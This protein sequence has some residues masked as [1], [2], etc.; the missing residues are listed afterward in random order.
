M[1]GMVPISLPVLKHPINKTSQIICKTLDTH[2]PLSLPVQITDPEL[3][4]LGPLTPA[5]L[6]DVVRH[7]SSRGS[8]APWND[9]TLAREAGFLSCA[10]PP[11]ACNDAASR[12]P[13][14]KPGGFVVQLACRIIAL[15][16]ST[17]TLT[18]SLILI[19]FHFFIMR[20]F[21]ILA[22][23]ALAVNGKSISRFGRCGAD[24]G[25]LTCA[26]SAFG[27]CCSKYNYCGSSSA[28]CD[29]GCQSGYG[30]CASSSTSSSPSAG[31][32]K[33]SSEG[34]CGGKG[35]KTC[36][37]SSFGN[38]CSKHG[39]CGS[40]PTYCGTGCNAAFG[41]CS[42]S[43][44]APVNVPTTLATVTRS[45]AAAPSSDVR[46][47]PNARCGWSR[48]AIGG[49]NCIGSRWGNCCSTWGFCGSTPD[50]C[51]PTKCQDKYGKCEST[52][53]FLS[54]SSATKS[55][56]SVAVSSTLSSASFTETTS[57]S[58]STR[59]ASSTLANSS[60]SS[61]TSSVTSSATSSSKTSSV[62]SSRSTTVS[63]SSSKTSSASS[64]SSA[65]SYSSS[66]SF[67]TTKTSSASS[68]SQA[69]SASSI[70]KASSS[71]STANTS[72][73]ISTRIS[74]S[75]SASSTPVS[76][77][78]SV[79]ST[80]TSSSSSF[81]STMTSSSSIASSTKTSSSSSFSASST[82]SSS[83]STVSSTAA[84]SSSSATSRRISS[85]SS[86]ISS[87]QSSS[88]SSSSSTTVLSSTSTSSSVSST[89]ASSSSSSVASSTLNPSSSSSMMTSTPAV[90]TPTPTPTP[91]A[92]SSVAC[93]STASSY[94]DNGDFELA[95]RGW[96]YTT[97]DTTY[98]T[99]LQDKHGG[100]R[101]L[102]GKG[103]PTGQGR[104]SMSLTQSVGSD[105]PSGT[106]IE[107]TAW[108][109]PTRPN[110]C[111]LFIIYGSKMVRD[112][113]LTSAVWQKSSATTTVKEDTTSR[114]LVVRAECTYTKDM[115]L[116][117]FD[118]ISVTVV[119]GP[120]GEPVC[121]DKG[122][123][124]RT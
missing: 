89:Q 29:D 49:F 41:S 60:S 53:S 16:D 93:F 54:S 44:S 15:S 82:Q 61:Q 103:M 37:N 79:S 86:S 2:A 69:S 45:S 70:S 26:G 46:V 83:S 11:V 31:D 100:S 122:G 99:Y 4:S 47:S 18:L 92:T 13:L 115:D 51:A 74:S 17:T 72:S 59:T 78:S 75:S 20:P 22:L 64:S 96:Q 110:D 108:I 77:S 91:S 107:I 76:S 27:S 25:G 124:M 32:S 85:S 105:L 120:A 34:D 88:A 87:T 84:S 68:T 33:V 24:F 8:A 90:I 66:S 43:V 116:F 19:L 56:S 94:V 101:S 102:L 35:G 65:M 5:L 71:S 10:N 114:V 55:S 6:S 119:K 12:S 121:S 63:S 95:A 50:Y 3:R 104:A 117:M 98:T 36:L 39:Y 38:C 118:D 80:K 9:S 21:L 57:A 28:Y 106:E 7:L 62:T 30:T 40:G 23:T 109:K 58:S 81:S 14:S 123:P 112:F 67:S 52:S 111:A 113:R 42:G 1:S 48:G 73:S 97:K